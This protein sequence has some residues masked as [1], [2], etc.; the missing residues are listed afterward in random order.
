MLG[1]I[2]HRTFPFGF[3]SKTPL[4]CSPFP[5]DGHLGYFP[6]GP[7]IS[8]NADILEQ[9]NIGTKP[10][11]MIPQMAKLLMK[12]PLFRWVEGSNGRQGLESIRGC[13]SEIKETPVRMVSSPA[14]LDESQRLGLDEIDIPGSHFHPF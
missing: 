1:N 11:P 6:F 7:R 9:R 12:L 13:I 10:L 2:L 4:L 14:D 3:R 5:L 8:V